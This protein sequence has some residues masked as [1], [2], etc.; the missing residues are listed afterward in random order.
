MMDKLLGRFTLTDATRFITT[1][2][3]VGT[4]IWSFVH[5]VRNGLPDKAEAP[6]LLTVLGWII[7]EAS[8][9][10]KYG[11]GTTESSKNKTAAMVDM[12]A[13]QPPASPTPLP[14]VKPLADDLEIPPPPNA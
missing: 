6:L 5:M 7:S 14:S 11:N 13:R 2:A 12:A 10:L 1:N 8:A 3:L 9:A 4:I